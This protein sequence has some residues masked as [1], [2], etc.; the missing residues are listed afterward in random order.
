MAETTTYQVTLGDRLVR[1]QLRRDGERLLARVDDGAEQDVE[2]RHMRGTL[3]ALRIGHR[4]TELLADERDGTVAL[5]IAGLEYRAEVV[6]E[7]H[8][9]LA[10]VAG[11]R[12]GGHARRELRAPMPGLLVKVL[13]QPGDSIE[14]GQPLAV[15]QAMKM[16][17]E[18]SLPRA[19][20]VK[21]VA[22]QPGSTVEQ[23][24]VLVVVE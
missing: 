9:R 16:E 3:H 10:S 23:G 5:A 2:L 14:P 11:A 1:V 24:Q 21:E 22:A 12:G 17:N 20:T 19:G 7:A 8:A 4:R 15:L 6:D 13:C 18:L